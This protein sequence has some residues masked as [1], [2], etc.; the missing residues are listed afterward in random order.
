[1]DLPRALRITQGSRLALVGA[2][3]KTTTLFQAASGLP[4]PVLVTATT[5]L[6]TS[7]VGLAD[8]HHLFENPGET[9]LSTIGLSGIELFTGAEV[10]SGRVAGVSPA[11]LSALQALADARHLP[12][13]IEADGARQLPVK[14]PA[15]HEPAIP[16][17]TNIVVVT[18]GMSAL[19]KPLS[20]EWV[21]RPERF[22]QLSGLTPGAEITPA[23]LAKV[24]LHPQGGFKGIPAGARRIALLNQAD[25]ELLQAQ[26]RGLAGRLLEGFPSPLSYHAVVLASLQSSS[27]FAVHEPVAG[28]ILAAGEAKRFGQPKQLLPWQGQPLVRHACRVA[29]DAGLSP[30]IVV[31]GAYT[32][33]IRQALAGLDV[34]L[35]HNPDW[36]AGQSTS[37]RAGLDAASGGGAALFLLADQPL[38]TA[39]LLQALVEA[40][41]VSLSPVVAPLVDGRRANPV[42]FDQDTF[43][44]LHNLTGDV[45]GRAL[46]SK[47]SPEWLPWHDANLLLDID[48]PEDY[49]RLSSL[50]A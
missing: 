9:D 27:I 36:Q 44:E 48:T 45:G 34:V 32:P 46:F 20:P 33:Q 24:L 17:F 50:D 29:L 3:G 49:Q 6:A 14:A 23:A 13:L 16:P 37:I 30:V 41:S 25:S 18:A 2:G 10:E 43:P 19:G 31:S 38:V 35:V 22:A 28:I 12:L 47:Y 7:Q 8:H 15:E 4:P 11:A 40:H 39:S 5:H 21:H 1:M 42:L 26:A